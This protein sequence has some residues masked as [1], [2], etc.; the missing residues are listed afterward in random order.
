VINM[1][2]NGYLKYKGGKLDAHLAVN[3]TVELINAD[4]QEQIASTISH[5]TTAQYDFKDLDYNLKVKLR[6]TPFAP[7]LGIKDVK[8]GYVIQS[9]S[10][11][12]LTVNKGIN[13]E[14]THYEYKPLPAKPI[15]NTNLK[16]KIKILKAVEI[17]NRV[18]IQ[19]L[20]E[21]SGKMVHFNVNFPRALAQKKDF[22]LQEI[23]NQYSLRKNNLKNETKERNDLVTEGEIEI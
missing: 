20:I 7:V 21:D 11:F 12:V 2:I 19:T 15:D 17:H 9:T 8:T 14:L 13:L 4:T 18:S 5:N 1:E 23:K 16:I 6:I 22:L 3:C 10:P